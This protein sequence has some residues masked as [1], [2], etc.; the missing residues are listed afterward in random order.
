MINTN[1]S[2]DGIILPESLHTL[3]LGDRVEIKPYDFKLPAAL[4]VLICDTQVDPI[5]QGMM[6]HEGLQE[7]IFNGNVLVDLT[8][9]VLPKSIRTLKLG[10]PYRTYIRYESAKLHSRPEKITKCVAPRST[11]LT[12]L[13]CDNYLM[14]FD[15]SRIVHLTIGTEHDCY[16][17]QKHIALCAL[18][19]LCVQELTVGL[20]PS[21]RFKIDM[22]NVKFRDITTIHD[23]SCSININSCAFPSTL[24]KIIHYVQ[25]KDGFTENNGSYEE[26]RQLVVY[27]RQ[28]GHNGQHTKAALHVKS[29]DPIDS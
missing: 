3:I 18:D 5:L 7:L 12:S 29:I 21:L 10:S 9:V 4:H 20:R 13:T 8:D 24:R 16:W 25:V 6:F 17:D 2:L 11:P 22:K 1:Q 27:E 15:S 19:L 23:Y 28:D 26:F 14:L